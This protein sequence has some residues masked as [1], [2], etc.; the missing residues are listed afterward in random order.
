[1]K[2]AAAPG[3]SILPSVTASSNSR[4]THTV[5]VILH[6]DVDATLDP[7]KSAVAAAAHIDAA[8]LE[9][10]PRKVRLQVQER[11]LEDLAV[12]WKIWQLSTQ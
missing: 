6:D 7:V 4:E 12:I 5:D 3:T 1:M 11:Y 2:S 10:S 9:S 8:T